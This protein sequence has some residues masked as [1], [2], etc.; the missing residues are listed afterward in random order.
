MVSILPRYPLKSLQ[1]LDP[2]ITLK[3]GNKTLLTERNRHREDENDLDKMSELLIQPTILGA[4]D[5]DEERGIC[6]TY[7]EES[8]ML[9]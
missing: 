8:S 1:L 9:I 3:V 4:N 7:R 6:S 2:K 5:L